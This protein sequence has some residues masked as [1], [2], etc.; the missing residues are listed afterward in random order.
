MWPTPYT[1]TFIRA[2]ALGTH[3]W[4]VPVGKRALV[5]EFTCMNFA[6]PPAAVWVIVAGIYVAYISFP[7][8]NA[9][10]AWRGL[11][12][13]YAGQTVAV[14]IGTAGMHST[15]SGKLLADPTGATAA[16]GDV[17]HIALDRPEELPSG[18]REL[19]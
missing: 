2:G 12:V 5:T 4:T 14:Q 15:L 10:N 17:R 19:G 18:V 13:A 9:F 1:E 3:S 16:P 6:A 7:A 8:Q 11:A